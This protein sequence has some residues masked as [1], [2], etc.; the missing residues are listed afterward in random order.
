MN[1]DIYYLFNIGK[2][3]IYIL[4]TYDIFAIIFLL[5]AV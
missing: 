3:Y 4:V 5:Y 1:P 2:F